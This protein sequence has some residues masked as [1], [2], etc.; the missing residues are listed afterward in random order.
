MSFRSSPAAT[1]AAGSIA[2]HASPGAR[3][4]IDDISGI[5]FQMWLPPAYDATDTEKRWLHL[6]SLCMSI[7]G[8]PPLC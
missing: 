7:V 4:G 8:L 3:V 1:L 5:N 6:E 2:A